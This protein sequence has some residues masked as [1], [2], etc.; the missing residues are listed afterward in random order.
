MHEKEGKMDE[1]KILNY[2]IPLAEDGFEVDSELERSLKLFGSDIDRN[3]P[4]F[5]GKRTVREGAIVK[6][7]ALA[8]TL[9][10]IRDKGPDYFYNHIGFVSISFLN[11]N[12]FLCFILL[13]KI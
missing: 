12:I 3:S 7:P 5:K 1:K 2:V 11:F 9:K 8:N 6:Q 13:S 10:K 4:F